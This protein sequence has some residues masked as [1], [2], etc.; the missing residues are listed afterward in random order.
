MLSSNNRISWCHGH[1]NKCFPAWQ[2][3]FI[4]GQVEIIPDL[5][6]MANLFVILT[7][8]IFHEI[9]NFRDIS[10]KWKFLNIKTLL[11]VI[12]CSISMMPY[13]VISIFLDKLK[14]FGASKKWCK[15]NRKFFDWKPGKWVVIWECSARA[16]QWTPTWQGLDGFQKS[17]CHCTLGEISL[18]IG[19]GS[20]VKARFTFHLLWHICTRNNWVKN[21][22]LHLFHDVLWGMNNLLCYI[23]VSKILFWYAYL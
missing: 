12:N 4:A 14:C 7:I 16:F 6:V 21:V 20:R 10:S 13:P 22:F 5:P 9:L 11:L 3:K 17:F 19:R 18:S 8:K 1:W 15:K 2:V 23:E